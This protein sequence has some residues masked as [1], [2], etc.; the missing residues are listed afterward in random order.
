MLFFLQ[1]QTLRKYFETKI[2]GLDLSVK[3][4]IRCEYSGNNYT[5]KRKHL[6]S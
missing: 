2:V 1:R 5:E 4:N 3:P 6:E